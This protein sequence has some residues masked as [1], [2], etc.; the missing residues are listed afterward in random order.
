MSVRGPTI[1]VVVTGAAEVVVHDPA[2][3]ADPTPWLKVR[4]S[5]K[6]MGVQDDL[7]VVAAGRAIE[8]AGLPR[9][10]GERAG[11]FLAVGYIPFEKKDIDPVLAASLDDAGAF[12]MARFSNG[13]FQKAHPLL[14]FRCLPNMPAYHVSVCFD[15]QGPYLVT[16]PG[17]AQFYLALEEAVA[18]LAEDRVDV[19]LV[20]GVA[21]QRNFLVEHH[22][23]RV[24]PPVAASELRDAA[25]VLVLERATSARARGA[26]ARA[27]L[28][29]FTLSYTPFDA[30]ES[31]PHA[32][33]SAS[34]EGELGAASVPAAVARAIAQGA[35]TSHRTTSRD[36][37]SG[38]S[39][40]R[41]PGIA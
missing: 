38:E 4:K 5:R 8:A 33:D 24:V 6:Y 37:L 40:W 25:A 17:A 22:F 2:A 13:G 7:A 28:S 9:A 12:S 35:D 34:S 16:Y 11:L 14:T 21:H 41:V 10:L 1:D 15:V 18:A 3:P 29:S 31:M 20:G 39:T 26:T 32:F 30:L 23:S 27:A 19:A 36:G